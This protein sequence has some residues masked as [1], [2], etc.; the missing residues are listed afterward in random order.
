[1]AWARIGK[2]IEWLMVTGAMLDCSF[3]VLCYELL[4]CYVIGITHRLYD[5]PIY[6]VCALIFYD[7]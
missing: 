2:Q 7:V 4:I 1:M 6:L 5:V 3:Y